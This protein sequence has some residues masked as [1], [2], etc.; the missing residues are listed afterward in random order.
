MSLELK[1][2]CDAIKRDTREVGGSSESR[3]STRSGRFG[4]CHDRV[5]S[6]RFGPRRTMRRE[7]I[8]SVRSALMTGLNFGGGSEFAALK[9]WTKPPQLLLIVAIVFL[10]NSRRIL[11]SATLAPHI[12]HLPR[13]KALAALF[14]MCD[15]SWAM[16][17][18]DVRRRMS[19]GFRPS[20]SLG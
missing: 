4:S 20:F 19:T 13:L 1:R 15:E 12:Q 8:W 2:A 7:E 9:L 18:S 14:F 10:V 6:F 3:V 11:M 16:G 17:L 5:C